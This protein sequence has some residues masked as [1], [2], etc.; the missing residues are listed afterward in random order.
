MMRRLV[1]AIILICPVLLLCGCWDYTEIE[2]LDFVLG[3]G[4]DQVEPDYLVVTE[5]IKTSGSAQEAQVE[6][7]VLTTHGRSLSS[8]AWALSSPAGRDVFWSHAQVF[9]VSEEVARGGILSAIEYAVRSP[10]MRSTVAMFVTRDCTVEEV[11]KSK[12]PFNDTVSE[13]LG[14]LIDLHAVVSNF[15]PQQVW[16]FTSDLTAQGISGTLPTIQLVHEQGEKVPIVKGTAVFKKDRMVGW[17]DGEESALFSLLK[18]KSQRDH[19]VMETRTSEGSFPI[20]YQIMGNKVDIK[21]VVKGE[22]PRMNIKISLQLSVVEVGHGAKISFQNEQEV[23]NIEEQIAHTFN[24]RTKDLIEKL[25]L[26]Y[27]SDILGFGQLLR[28]KEPDIWRRYSE[29]WDSFFPLLDVE[30][31]VKCTIAFTGLSSQP[32]IVRD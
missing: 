26:E 14:V 3:A 4:L 19:F 21:P 30:V 10:H 32:I 8:A 22:R 28:R 29:D 7:V 17:L 13:H 20:T 16:E 31:E 27:N 6:T 15:Y 1:W 23:K 2:I 5:M 9:L 11:F 18:G 24:R 25:Q 12:P